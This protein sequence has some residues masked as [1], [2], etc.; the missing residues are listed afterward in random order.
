[1]TDAQRL[2]FRLGSGADASTVHLGIAS[3]ALVLA[4]VWV[5]WITFGVF[6][7][8]HDGNAQ[9]FDVAW[10]VLRASIVLMVLGYYLR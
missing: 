1:M 9:L 5:L 8:W 6:R 7:S 3:A 4:F 10:S 2:A